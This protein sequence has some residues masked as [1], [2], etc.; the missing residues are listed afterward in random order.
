MSSLRS[1]LSDTLAAARARA[2]QYRSLLTPSPSG[3]SGS[4]SLG[5]GVG[6]VS[7]SSLGRQMAGL[8]TVASEGEG[9]SG[10]FSLC[11]GGSGAKNYSVIV[12]APELLANLCLGVV[13]NGVKFCMASCSDCTVGSHSKKVMVN[14]DHVYINAGKNAAFTDPHLPVS[15]MG[16]D[17]NTYLGELRP[18][19]D[20]LRIFQ[21]YM[22]ENEES[23]TV[24]KV[25]VT[26]KKR[27][28]RF[29]S[30]PIMT[31]TDAGD[32]LLLSSSWEAT[33]SNEIL[34]A[35]TTAF[36]QLDQRLTEFQLSAGDDVDTL[37]GRTQDIK[38][39]IGMYPSGMV[40]DECNTIWEMFA[41][42]RNMIVEPEVFKAAETKITTL[43]TKSDQFQ[44]QISSL[45]STTN[46]MSELI[47]LLSMEQEN[48][49]GIPALASSSANIQ[50]LI[51][52]LEG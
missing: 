49:S 23:N 43:S 12:L 50:S 21:A 28:H 46:D 16:S 17:L 44:Q 19:E 39:S 30:D 7:F 14:P 32:L 2:S 5:R 40:S 36:Q 26:P 13:N 11:V 6:G 52:Q 25:L 37:F 51:Q 38:A 3:S 31:E 35:L 29:L 4:V 15:Y 9:G 18:R 45:T 48:H 20:W 41:I 33:D 27:K 24:S 22:E 47:Q 1:N 34:K 10:E 42:L 8:S